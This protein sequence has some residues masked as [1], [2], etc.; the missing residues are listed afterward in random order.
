[1][2]SKVCFLCSFDQ[3]S[4]GATIVC[5]P[6]KNEVEAVTGKPSILL[7]NAEST[8]QFLQQLAL[9]SLDSFCSCPRL[10]HKEE[11]GMTDVR[12]VQNWN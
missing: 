10:G 3:Q 4:Q 12:M 9:M 6:N 1:M 11:R 5:W 2:F 8:V 7:P